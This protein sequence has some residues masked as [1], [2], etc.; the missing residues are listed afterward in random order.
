MVGS[1]S[2]GGSSGRLPLL[3]PV[4]QRRASSSQPLL[5]IQQQQQQQQQQLSPRGLR[6]AGADTASVSGA[7]AGTGW[8]LPSEGAAAQRRASGPLPL[9][10]SPPS[11]WQPQ[12]LTMQ[13]SSGSGSWNG[14]AALS[15]RAPRSSDGAGDIGG[16]GG[17]S[18]P[19]APRANVGSVGGAGESG[20]CSPRAPR[21]SG[22]FGGGGGSGP[23]SPRAPRASG[24]SGSGFGG[25]GGGG[26]GGGVS[27]GS[28]S[29]MSR[30]SSYSGILPAA[31]TGSGAALVPTGVGFGANPLIVMSLS[32]R[33]SS[34]ERLPGVC[35]SGLLRNQPSSTAAGAGIRSYAAHDSAQN[36]GEAERFGWDAAAADTQAEPASAEPAVTSAAMGQQQ[37]AVTPASASGQLPTPRKRS[38]SLLSLQTYA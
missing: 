18:S 1:G 28:S 36:A 10:P 25:A 4:A 30:G 6:A 24:G 38:P 12:Q 8:M 20:P 13:R 26:G 2:G 35:V 3:T 31:G 23:C 34:S 15:P 11:S 5:F 7:G 17:A 21:A 32:P 14:G 29:R 37:P 19:R 22:G 27:P 9:Q 16:G 33:T